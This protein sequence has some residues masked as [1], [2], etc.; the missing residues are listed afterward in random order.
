MAILKDVLYDGQ[1]SDSGTGGTT[2]AAAPLVPT[3]AT[4]PTDTLVDTPTAPSTTDPT[5]IP[6]P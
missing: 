3:A 2:A 6:A 5:L 4:A 1:P